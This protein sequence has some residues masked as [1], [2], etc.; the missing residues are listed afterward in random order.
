MAGRVR[1]GDQP[2]C[3]LLAGT[4]ARR[5]QARPG[6]H[7]APSGLVTMTADAVLLI[8]LENMIGDRAKPPGLA[9][10]V[11]VLTTEAGPGVSTVAVCAASR[12]TQAGARALQDRGIK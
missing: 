10:K 9:A 12:I 6:N 2:A 5:R 1:C 11:D 8:D 4:R 7:A 3:P